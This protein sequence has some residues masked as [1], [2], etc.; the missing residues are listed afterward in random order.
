M[1]TPPPA[2]AQRTVI[3]EFPNVAISVLPFDWRG[4]WQTAT[5]DSCAPVTGELRDPTVRIGEQGVPVIRHH[6]HGVQ[7]N[8]VARCGQGDAAA[9]ERGAHATGRQ[10]G[11]AARCTDG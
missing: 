4:A 11:S 10:E 1:A 5:V 8:A 7:G 3:G 2:R 6:Y 9:H